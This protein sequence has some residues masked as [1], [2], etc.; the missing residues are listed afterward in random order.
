MYEKYAFMLLCKSK[1]Y[2][3]DGKDWEAAIIV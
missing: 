1:V 3:L 2:G